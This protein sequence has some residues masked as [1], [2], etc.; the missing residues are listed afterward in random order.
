MILGIGLTY[1]GLTRPM[2]QELS[3]VR[4]EV[5]QASRDIALL[6]GLRDQWG[7]A[8]DVTAALARSRG[9]IDEA[10]GALRS[11]RA[12]RSEWMAEVQQSQVAR[13]SVASISGQREGFARGPQSWV[14][15]MAPL[16]VERRAVEQIRATRQELGE[17]IA[18]LRDARREWIE[19]SK[20]L[21]QT[22]SHGT[23]LARARASLAGLTQIK[24]ELIRHSHDIEFA[25]QRTESILQ[26]MG[27]LR[28]EGAMVGSALDNLN[29]LHNLSLRVNRGSRDIAGAVETL[30]LLSGFRTELTA[31][32]RKIAGLKQSLADIAQIAGSTEQILKAIEPIAKLQ[33]LRE[34]SDAD[35]RAAARAILDRRTLDGTANGTADESSLRPASDQQPE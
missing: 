25:R 35:I 2:L 26:V 33:D 12:L 29:Q 20:L 28:Q 7:V 16:A 24:S 3:E 31:E 8:G 23:D 15:T 19:M 9:E 6:A 4:H 1:V 14:G 30:D 10:W 5:R 17:E 11:I 21:Q 18:S 22:A 13:A 34:Q 32:S 27:Q